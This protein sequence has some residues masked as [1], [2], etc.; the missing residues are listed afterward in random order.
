MAVNATGGYEIGGLGDE[1]SGIHKSATGTAPLFNF[2][3]AIGLLWQII[4]SRNLFIPWFKT[5]SW[6]SIYE[7]VKTVFHVKSE[8][9]D[10]FLSNSFF[11]KM[12]LRFTVL[13]GFL[14][15]RYLE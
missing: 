10:G 13:S 7:L 14:F 5:M 4:I 12:L 2:R 9:L 8:L 11:L 3:S 6:F 15:K 1:D